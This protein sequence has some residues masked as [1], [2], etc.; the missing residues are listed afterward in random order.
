MPI[1][2]LMASALREAD[3]AA[4]PVPYMISGGTDAKAM[5][6]LGIDSYGF[7]PLKMPADLDYWTLFHGVDER[8]PIEGLHFGVDVLDRFLRQA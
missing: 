1:V 6:K 4:R 2:D 3:S 7:S 8:V 5:V